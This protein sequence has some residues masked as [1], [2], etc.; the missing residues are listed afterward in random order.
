MDEWLSV[1]DE[2]FVKKAEDRMQRIVRTSD[3]LVLASHSRELIERTC[4]TVIW[5]E[6]VKSNS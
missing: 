3:I 5:L 4:R 6:A 2:K 1:G